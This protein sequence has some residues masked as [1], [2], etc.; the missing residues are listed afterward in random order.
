MNLRASL[1]LLASAA[2]PAVG[3]DTKLERDFQQTVRPFLAKNCISC[4]SG[5]NPAAQ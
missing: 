5:Q 2:F 4:H 1:A 3:A